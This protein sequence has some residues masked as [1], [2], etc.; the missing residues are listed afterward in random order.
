MP[1]N[2]TS[3]DS[4][5]KEILNKILEILEINE[6]NKSFLLQD[7]DD[8]LEKQ[9]LI[10]DLEPD[11]KKYFLTSK[12]SCFFK[13]NEQQRKWYNII[14]TV[15]KDLDID[16]CTK[17]KGCKVD[18]NKITKTEFILYFNKSNI[19]NIIFKYSQ[20]HDNENNDLDLLINGKVEAYLKN[21]NLINTK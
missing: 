21:C 15:F 17:R 14:K 16:Y 3:F 13:S 2:I 10:Y 6:F 18:G 8:L 1:K 12:W 7:M 9:Q 5:R 20:K 11:I 4:E 19:D